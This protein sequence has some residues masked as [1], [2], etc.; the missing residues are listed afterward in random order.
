MNLPEIQVGEKIMFL[1][2]NDPCKIIFI[3]GNPMTLQLPP[4]IIMKV[5]E[6]EP[7][8]KGATAAAQYKPATMDTG[9]KIQVP[10]FIVEGEMI[11]VDTEEKKYLGR[12]K[13]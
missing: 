7:T 12:S 13:E 1:R 5:I 10:S 8:I 9:L 2:E 6:T 4:S 11:V 3:N